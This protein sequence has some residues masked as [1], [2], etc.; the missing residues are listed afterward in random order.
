M[1]A[2]GSR[3]DS[4]GVARLYSRFLDDIIISD[5]DSAMRE[6]IEKLGVHCITTD[7]RMKGPDDE[8]RLA[9]VLLEV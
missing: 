2:M 7:T 6:R 9:K 5:S 1:R 3:P 4:V 8:Q